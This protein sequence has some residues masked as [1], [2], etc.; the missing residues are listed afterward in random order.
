MNELS[1]SS[2]GIVRVPLSDPLRRPSPKP[3]G[4]IP[5]C[6]NEIVEWGLISTTTDRNF[7]E[8]GGL[9]HDCSTWE[10]I[11]DYEDEENADNAW[12]DPS[13]AK[14]SNDRTPANV[15]AIA[16]G[17]NALEPR[18]EIRRLSFG[19][20]PTALRSEIALSRRMNSRECPLRLQLFLQCEVYV[21]MLNGFLLLWIAEN[22]VLGFTCMEHEPT[23]CTFS[24]CS[25]SLASD[26]RECLSRAKMSRMRPMSFRSQ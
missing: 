20:M 13:K 22:E 19:R 18:A 3:N 1:L 15:L 24:M 9:E 17:A 4:Q 23:V 8:C 14:G 7:V 21:E 2:M 10:E 6:L 16:Q 12:N 5:L 25:A 11:Y 26:C